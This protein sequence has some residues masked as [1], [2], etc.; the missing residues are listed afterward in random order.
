MQAVLE[1]GASVL[2]KIAKQGS[3]EKTVGFATA[4]QAS[5]NQ[6]QKMIFGVDSPFPVEISQA[7]A[8]SM[9]R[10]QITCYLPAGTNPEV[11]GIASYRQDTH[12]NIFASN[13][14]YISIRLYDRQ[15]AQLIAG[16]EYCKVSDYTIA[17]RTRNL[18]MVVLNF[19][20]MYIS[21]GLPG[22]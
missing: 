15:S 19:E 7:A 17:A 12:G 3:T 8:P 14:D 22:A 4:F 20:G 11:W 2:L 21:P 18:I 9:V 16:C 1:T 5:V 13:S 10:G 6:G